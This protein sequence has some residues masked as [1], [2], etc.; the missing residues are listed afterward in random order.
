MNI[1]A[2]AA[3]YADARASRR[4][5]VSVSHDHRGF[6]P[7]KGWLTGRAGGAWGDPRAARTASITDGPMWIRQ[8]TGVNNDR[9]PITAV[10]EM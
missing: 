7:V 10:F 3:H 8:P 6:A 4:Q 5:N 2:G 9:P 1:A